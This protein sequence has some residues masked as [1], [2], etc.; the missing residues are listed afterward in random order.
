LTH[1]P[2]DDVTWSQLPLV[3]LLSAVLDT[4]DPGAQRRLF[5]AV[6]QDARQHGVGG[7]VDSWGAELAVLRAG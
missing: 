2:F 6:E 7:V 1:H 4:G 3:D 5:A